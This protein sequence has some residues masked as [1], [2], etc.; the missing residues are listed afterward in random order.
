M[1]RLG[2]IEWIDV[3]SFNAR[4]PILFLIEEQINKNGRRMNQ[5]LKE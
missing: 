2:I 5:S 1:E 4:M 3:P